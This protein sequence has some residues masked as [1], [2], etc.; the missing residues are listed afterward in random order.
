MNQRPP[1]YEAGEL[2]L[3]HPEKINQACRSRTCFTLSPRQVPY[4]P[5]HACHSVSPAGLEPAPSPSEGDMRP[6]HPEDTHVHLHQYPRLESNQDVFDVRSVACFRH[7]PGTRFGQ[8]PTWESN[9][10]RRFRKPQCTSVTPVRYWSGTRMTRSGIRT[11]ITRSRI[12][13]ASGSRTL[14]LLFRNR[15]RNRQTHA[16]FMSLSIVKDQNEKTHLSFL[17]GVLFF[18]PRSRFP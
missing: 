9:P 4:R 11:R 10:V 17:D 6:S 8:Y 16:R 12:S 5:A 3:L 1:A 13:R 15:R 18:F 7:T 2:P 14:F